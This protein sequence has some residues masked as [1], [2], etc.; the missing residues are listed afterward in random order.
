MTQ[1]LSY[2]FADLQGYSRTGITAAQRADGTWFEVG[3]N[4][5]ARDARGLAI[6]NGVT[7]QA[8]NPRAVGTVAGTPGTAPTG[9]G[10]EGTDRTI[11]GLTTVQGL[12]LLDLT[13]AP[14][15][16]GS[17]NRQLTL[18]GN[19]IAA[20]AG[21][22][23]SCSLFVSIISGAGVSARLDLEYRDANGALVANG[24]FTS[25]AL[26]TISANLTRL[27]VSGT[28]PAGT[29][30]ITAQLRLDF[31]GATTSRI[32]YGLP[33]IELSSAAT[34]PVLPPAGTIAAS[35]RAA[36][37]PVQNLQPTSPANAAAVTVEMGFLIPA[38]FPSHILW[39]INAAGVFTDRI[40]LG[41]S[42]GQARVH[43]FVGNV[44]T[45]EYAVGAITAG[46]PQAVAISWDRATNTIDASVNGGPVVTAVRTLPAGPY[47]E[48]RFGWTGVNFLQGYR[49]RFALYPRRADRD[50]RFRVEPEIHGLRRLSLAA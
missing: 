18:E 28:A 45:G 25:A 9:W 42:G 30:R 38:F 24:S 43:T 17:T 13:Y 34:P 29:A 47:T 1:L 6:F 22:V 3:A 12:T 40:I 2:E 27:T 5:P 48:L 26:S 21:D 35:T 39:Q 14:P 23:W 32:R 11:H 46:V 50:D 36:D 8:R 16:P 31:T 44:S 37:Q 33:Q 7:N 4:V 49:R 15:G 10:N 19:T 20:A 41:V